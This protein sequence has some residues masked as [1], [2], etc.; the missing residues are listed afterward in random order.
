M[1]DTTRKHPPAKDVLPSVVDYSKHAC[2]RSEAFLRVSQETGIPVS[3]LRVA[4]MREGVIPK[5]HSLKYT[6]SEEEEEA[7]V[8]ACVIYARQGIP[9]TVRAFI[10]MASRYAGFE[11]GRFLSYNFAHTFIERKSLDLCMKTGKQTSPT[12]CM[13]TMQQLTENFV[14]LIQGYIGRNIMNKNN[15]VVF[16]ETVV[17]DLPS[18][19]LCGLPP[20]RGSV[21]AEKP[22]CG[23]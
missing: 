6:F 3:T 23:L 11:E 15:I 19:P 17:G 5:E 1:A 4:A 16:D 10:K 8:A 13:E 7:L 18:L 12:R 14:A 9:L 21:A 20:R 22:R 2:T